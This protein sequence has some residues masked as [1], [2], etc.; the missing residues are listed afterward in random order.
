MGTPSSFIRRARASM[1]Q[2]LA[3]SGGSSVASLTRR[4]TSSAPYTGGRPGRSS[5]ASPATPMAW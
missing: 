5:S 3:G 1:V 4:S 2:R